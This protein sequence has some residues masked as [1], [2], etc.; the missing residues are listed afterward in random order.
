MRDVAYVEAP[1]AGGK[2]GEGLEGVERGERGG[3]EVFELALGREG[4]GLDV[5][6]QEGVGKEKRRAESQAEDDGENTNAHEGMVTNW[7]GDDRSS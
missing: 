4:L 6:V 7:A 2:L 1:V 3:R 5:D